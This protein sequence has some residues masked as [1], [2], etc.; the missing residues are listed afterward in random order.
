MPRKK[1]PLLA[2]ALASTVSTALPRAAAYCATVAT[3]LT[4][5]GAYVAPARADFARA[6][7]ALPSAAVALAAAQR[8]P[9]K[10]QALA[11]ACCRRRCPS[12]PLKHAATREA[13]LAAGRAAAGVVAIVATAAN[14]NDGQSRARRQLP[15]PIGISPC[16]TTAPSIEPNRHTLLRWWLKRSARA[17]LWSRRRRREPFGRA[18]RPLVEAVR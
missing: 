10:P 3:E 5:V 7:G 12:R 17:A 14:S 16:H 8:P 1:D 6:A 2:F 15:P 11:V 13:E 9:E 4:L 18:G